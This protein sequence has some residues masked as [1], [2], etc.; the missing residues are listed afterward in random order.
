MFLNSGDAVTIA[1]EGLGKI[2]HTVA[3]FGNMA[4]ASLPVAFALAR[5]RGTIVDGDRVLWLGLASGI[6]VGAVMMV[7]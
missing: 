1:I 5:E 2:E 7:A 4:A 6:S 3:D